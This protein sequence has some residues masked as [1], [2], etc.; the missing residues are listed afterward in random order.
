MGDGGFDCCRDLGNVTGA[1]STRNH[2]QAEAVCLV[3]HVPLR[4][5][6]NAEFFN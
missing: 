2:T 3:K 4:V 5:A 1:V 6:M